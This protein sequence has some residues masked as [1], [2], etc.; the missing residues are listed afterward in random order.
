MAADRTVEEP[1]RNY[2]EEYES[3][4]LDQTDT[5]QSQTTRTRDDEGIFSGKA[6]VPVFN[7][8]NNGMGPF[9]GNENPIAF[10]NSLLSS[11]QK[12]AEALKHSKV[13]LVMEALKAGG[14]YCICRF[15]FIFYLLTDLS[16]TIFFYGIS[17]NRSFIPRG[18]RSEE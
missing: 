16:S 12:L 18:H 11:D 17:H 1:A 7:N 8:N 2:T 5:N 4:L 3:S 13:A 15:L 9:N 6:G 14:M 10:I